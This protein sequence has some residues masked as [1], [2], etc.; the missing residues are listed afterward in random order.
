MATS[1]VLRPFSPALSDTSTT[2]PEGT[3]L[4]KA[5]G[6]PRRLDDFPNNLGS[7]YADLK[8]SIIAEYG[9]EN[10]RKSWTE[11]CNRLN[12]HVVPL[13]KSLGTE[14]VPSLSF[15]DMLALSDEHR[16]K[17]R[18]AGCV[19]VRG[20]FDADLARR[21][22]TMSKDYIQANKEIAKGIPRTSDRKSVW[23]VYWSPAQIAA[24]EHENMLN[25]QVALN[26]LWTDTNPKGEEQLN[27][28]QPYSYADRVRHREPGDT[29][30]ALGPHIDGGSLERWQDPQYRSAY[31]DILNGDFEKFE[32]YNIRPRLTATQDLYGGTAASSVLRTW[33]GWTSLSN[34]GPGEGSLSLFPRIRESIAYVMLRPFF[35]PPLAQDGKL[36]SGWPDPSQWTLDTTSRFPGSVGGAS[37]ELGDVAHPH[38]RLKECLVSIPRVYP[39]DGVF[40]HCDASILVNEQYFP[41]TNLCDF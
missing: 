23:H 20:L 33:Q 21:W 17:I 15:Q 22:E 8:A 38:L 27:L 9:E 28:N 24:R 3:R 11:V 32:D 30:F 31:K 34:T 12:D 13:L 39:G 37:Q 6:W 10:L 26:N 29:N 4:K 16:A 18:E 7:E 41:R 36:A 1:T 19:V 40:W 5:F 35:S 2:V 25:V 14:T